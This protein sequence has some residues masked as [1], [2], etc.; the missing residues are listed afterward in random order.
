MR[1]IALIIIAIFLFCPAGAQGRKIVVDTTAVVVA[2]KRPAIKFEI[3][4]HTF[5]TI[6]ISRNPKREHIFTFTNTGEADLYILNVA[7]GCGCTT[8]TYTKKAIKPGK[9][10]KIKVEYDATGR[11]PGYYRKSVTV[12][13]N[14]PS[15]Y[16]RLF[17]DGVMV[18]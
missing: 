15:S 11:R 7:T 9:K 3:R 6:S 5:D 17:I 18:E 10:G 12:Y 4:E 2:K 1:L 8:P 14:D 16:V 13:S